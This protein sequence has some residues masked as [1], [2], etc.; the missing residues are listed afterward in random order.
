MRNR[1][2]DRIVSPSTEH[3]EESNSAPNVESGSAFSFCINCF[4]V[5]KYRKTSCQPARQIDVQV[6]DKTW[7]S[8]NATHSSINALWQLLVCVSCVWCVLSC[9]LCVL[10]ILVL[11]AC[12]LFLRLL[13]LLRQK[14]IKILFI[15]P[16]WWCPTQSRRHIWDFSPIALHATRHTWTRPASTP[17]IQAGTRFTY[18]GEMKGWVDTSTKCSLLDHSR[19]SVNFLLSNS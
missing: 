10:C 11:I 16:A 4:L 19:W 5:L 6:S 3:C 7:V 9:V 12:V 2:L 18:P 14:V 1:F 17:A 15:V 13:H 8:S